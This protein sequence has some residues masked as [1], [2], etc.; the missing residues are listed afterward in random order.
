MAV[1]SPAAVIE[2]NDAPVRR[3][4]G[5]ELITGFCTADALAEVE[6]ETNGLRFSIDLLQR[7]EDR[8]LPRSGR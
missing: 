5:L 2:R 1:L 7:A 3:A 8:F 6:I 4:E